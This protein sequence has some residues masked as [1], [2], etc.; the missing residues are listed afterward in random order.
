MA[1]P[2]SHTLSKS[3][4]NRYILGTMFVVVTVFAIWLGWELKFVRERKIACARANDRTLTIDS[5][6]QWRREMHFGADMPNH[7]DAKIPPWRR[8]MGDEPVA[9]I[10]CL[11][12]SEREMRRLFPEAAINVQPAPWGRPDN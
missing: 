12:D 6:Q 7:R 10:L 1:Y 3:A 9:C 11:S 8:W 5:V 4:R 2:L